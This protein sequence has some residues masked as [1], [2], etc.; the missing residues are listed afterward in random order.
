[1]RLLNFGLIV[2]RN[3]STVLITGMELY[4]ICPMCNLGR[5]YIIREVGVQLIGKCVCDRGR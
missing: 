5:S 2:T 4:W 3:R 1:M